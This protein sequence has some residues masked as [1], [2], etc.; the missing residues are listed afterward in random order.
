[1]RKTLLFFILGFVWLLALP[2]LAQEKPGTVAGVW[3]IKPKVGMQQQF[4]QALKRH[5]D[6]HRQQKDTWTV[7]VWQ[8]GTG[9]RTG[10]YGRGVFGLHWKDLDSRAKFMEADGADYNAN[11]AQYE[12]SEVGAVYLYHPELSRPMPGDVPT[13]IY[14]TVWYQLNMDGESDFLLAIRKAH[15]AIQKANW[16]VYYE[17]YE[18]FNGGEHP[19][20]VL[21][22]PHKNW[23]DFEPPEQTFRAVLEKAYGREEAESVLKLFDKSVHCVRSELAVSR[24]DLSYVP[25]AK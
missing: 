2:L 25:E 15:E 11:V 7:K 13:P 21:T 1:M 17:F 12:E 24:P 14:S 3:Y 22:F 19:T 8:V 4:E 5:M 20:Y 10:Q 9:E 6:W 16:P 18:L 23:A